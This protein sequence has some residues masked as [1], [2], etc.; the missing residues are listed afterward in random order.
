MTTTPLTVAATLE[1]DFHGTRLAIATDHPRVAEALESRFR[2]FRVEDSEPANVSFDISRSDR[3][4]AH[5]ASGRVVYESDLGDVVYS[6][7]GDA[8]AIRGDRFFVDADLRAAHVAIRYLT[9]ADDELALV[10]H[11][12]F[13]LPLMEILKTPAAVLV[14][15]RVRRRRPGRHPSGR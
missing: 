12:L 4:P 11:P 6:D 8:L 5:A 14:A 9:G 3:P 2:P 15:R 7:D 1:F 10:A 13:T